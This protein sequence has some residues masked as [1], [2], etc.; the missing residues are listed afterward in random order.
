MTRKDIAYKKEMCYNENN[1]LIRK[2]REVMK[3][4]YDTPD[5]EMRKVC[6][7]ETISASGDEITGDDNDLD[8]N[9]FWSNW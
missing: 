6:A 9:K 7:V 8:V 4:S 3:K 5:L 2:E 1:H